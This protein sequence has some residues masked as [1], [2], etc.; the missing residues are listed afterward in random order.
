V[1]AC[2][3]KLEHRADGPDTPLEVRCAIVD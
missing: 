2:T 1:E 3:M